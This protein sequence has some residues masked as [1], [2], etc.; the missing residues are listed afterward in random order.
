M[1]RILEAVVLVPRLTAALLCLV[2]LGGKTAVCAGWMP[3]PEARLACCADGGPCPMHAGESQEQGPRRV[4]TQLDADR[5][6]AAS[7]RE[8]SPSS[9]SFVTGISPAVLGP[10]V[11]LPASLPMLVLSDDWRTAAPV[12]PTPV[13]RHVLLSVFLV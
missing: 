13:P 11:M 12:A 6:C 10:G 2:L 9:P 8:S 3:S 7:E 4:P 5:C 1:A